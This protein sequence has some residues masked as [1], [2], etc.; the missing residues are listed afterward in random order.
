MA[1]GAPQGGR[2]GR[3][4]GLSSRGG[5]GGTG[6]SR[7]EVAVA[8]LHREGGRGHGR[9][10]RVSRPEQSAVAAGQARRRRGVLTAPVPPH[11][12]RA[13]VAHARHH[14]EAG[15]DAFVNLARDELRW[16]GGTRGGGEQRQWA[17]GGGRLEGCS[18]AQDRSVWGVQRRRLH[19]RHPAG[20]RQP[21]PA[22]Q[23]TLSRGNC[24]HSAWM[25]S[26]A[27]MR[28]RR[29]PTSSAAAAGS[30]VGAH[31]WSAGAR[32]CV[33][34]GVGSS[35]GE[36][37]ARQPRAAAGSTATRKRLPHSRT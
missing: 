10:D 8:V 34:V 18:R 29:E 7:A 32:A 21:L 22:S 24:R 3:R 30:Q 23:R 28:L 25:P 14:F 5:G 35:A 1:R 9:A 11:E 6:G 16:R 17:A 13:H 33:P 2:G 12:K 31:A 26:G 20:A 19:A 27:A 15:V 36:P 4:G 37:E